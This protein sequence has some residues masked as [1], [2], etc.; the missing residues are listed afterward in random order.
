MDRDNNSFEV[1]YVLEDGECRVYCEICDELCI[2]RYYENHL[3]TG[4]HTNNI[5]STK[6]NN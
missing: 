1:I 2:E 3:K 5:I 6:D 4:T